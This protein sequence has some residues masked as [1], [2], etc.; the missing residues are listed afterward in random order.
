M[1]QY[2]SNFNSNFSPVEELLDPVHKLRVS[3]PQAL[4]DTDFEYGLQTTKW[5][6]LEL[7][8]NVPA[9]YTAD[10]DSIL[11]GVTSVIATA[12]SNV[13]VVNTNAPH[14]LVQGTPID[15]RGLSYVAAEGQFLIQTVPTTTSFTY[16]ASYTVPISG[17]ISTPYTAVTPGQ[18]YAGSNIPYDTSV[19]LV[20]DGANPSN[21]TVNTVATHG[22]AVNTNFYAVNTIGVK[23]ITLTST[24]T[25]APDGRPYVDYT[26][27][28][29]DNFTID[30][31]MTETEQWQSGYFLK[32]KSSDVSTSASTITWP[33]HG[34][35]TNDTVVYV[36]P[37]GDTAIGG[38]SRFQVYYVINAGTNTIQLSTSVNGGPITFTSAGTSNYG[39]H[40][41][42]MCY[43]IM[44]MYK[45]NYTYQTFIY[46]TA[47]Y[48]GNGYS[49][50]DLQNGVFTSNG[51][52]GGSGYYGK[53]A[54]AKYSMMFSPT[55]SYV[56]PNMAGP[57]YSTQYSSG[58][59]MPETNTYPS[60]YNFIE[61]GL[62]YRYSYAIGNQGN[63]QF[64]N[65]PVIY[66]NYVAYNQDY[67]GYYSVYFGNGN[68][69]MMFL[70]DDP[71]A[72]TFYYPNHNLQSG[73]SVTLTVSSGST[74][75]LFPVVNYDWFSTYAYPNAFITSGSSSVVNAVSANRFQLQIAGDASNF[76]APSG[77]SFSSGQSF[78]LSQAAGTYAIVGTQP[79]ALANTFYVANHG[80][81]GGEKV[82]LT[83]SGGGSALP[84]VVSGTPV[85]NTNLTTGNIG[86]AFG[87][88]NNAL[89]TQ[90]TAAGSKVQN[91]ILNGTNSQFYQNSGVSSGSSPVNQAGYYAYSY[92]GANSGYPASGSNNYTFSLSPTDLMAGTSTANEG[93]TVAGTPW[94]QNSSVPHYSS[95]YAGPSSFSPYAN[96]QLSP[97]IYYLNYGSVTAG[98]YQNVNITGDWYYAWNYNIVSAT[99][100]SAG[101][102]AFQTW[103]WKD[104]WN[105][106]HQ[107]WNNYAYV[108]GGY[109][110]PNL[111]N[112]KNVY[113]Q[114][115]TSFMLPANSTFGL[116]DLQ[117]IVAGVMSSFATNFAYPT[118][119]T[120]NP[121]YITLVNSNRFALSNQVFPY[122]L[123][124]AGSPNI[125]FKQSGVSGLLDGTYPVSAVPNSKSFVLSLPY[126]APADYVY[127][128]AT[129][130]ASNLIK[131][132]AGHFFTNGTKVT[133]NNGG[134]TTI[135][136]LTNNATYYV[137]V[138]DDYYIGFATSYANTG[139]KTL[140][141]ISAGTGANH[142]VQ[143]S[144]IN[145]TSKAVGTVST[146]AAS[147][148]ITGTNA[149]LFTRYFKV[150]DNVILKDASTT[151]GTLYTFQIA[152]I[153]NDQTMT[154]VGSV[155]FTQ[156][157]VSYFYSTKLYVRPDGYAIHRPYD[158]GIELAAGTA[159]SSSIARQT[160]KYFRYQPGKGIQSSAGI[161]FNPAVNFNSLVL[162]SSG[163]TTAVGTASG[164]ATVTLSSANTN[165]YVGQLVTGT[166]VPTG[167]YVQSITD[168]THVVLTKSVTISS[169]T[170]TFSGYIATGTTRYPHRLTAGNT[171]LVSNSSDAAY[172][173]TQTAA[174]I[175]D[176]YTFTMPLASNPSTTIPGGLIQW[177]PQGYSG[178]YTRVGMF[179]Y[180]NGFFF[181]F[182][183]S[184]LW[185]VRRS[186][187]QQLS[188]SAT[189]VFGSNTITGVG[190]NFTGQLSSGDKIVVRGGTYRV[191]EVTSNTS[192]AI[193][194]QYKGVS[195]TNVIISKTIDTRVPQ[196]QWSL[197]KCDGTGFTG[198]NLNINKIQM[199]YLDYSWYGAGK[200]R[201]GFKD[202]AGHIKYVHEFIH[203]NLQDI[204]YMRSGNL[205]ARYEIEN[206][207]NPTYV[208]KLY[209]WGT[210]VIMDGNFDPDKAYLITASSNNLTFTNGQAN[211]ATTTAGSYVTQNYNSS[212]RTY[213]WYNVLTFSS[214]DAGKFATGTPLY[215]A[216]GQLNGSQTV[217][218][219]QYSGGS[220]LVYIFLQSGYYYPYNY[221]TIS[222][223]IS[224]TA[225]TATTGSS[226]PLGTALI[227]LISLRLAPS[228][229]SNLI[230]NLG[231]REIIN[232][233]QLHLNEAEITTTHDS[234]IYMILNG[235]LSN[236]NF[237][238]AGKP[239]LSQYVPHQGGDTISGGLSLY[240]FRASGGSVDQG[241]GRRLSNTN[242]FPLSGITDMGNSILG[243]N[244]TFPNGPDVLTIAA[245]VID[246][247]GIGSSQPYL[248]TGRMSWSESQA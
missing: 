61:N 191:V 6:T 63:Y 83:P 169:I 234:T 89:N 138:Q 39:R 243:G 116:S 136:G 228:V 86:S 44:Y 45:P 73:T 151:P 104:S 175:V 153:T 144:V 160:R 47:A 200:I 3:T 71:E 52:N 159:P 35:H 65:S 92:D 59:V 33:N 96:V 240:S 88:F 51:V 94:I 188:G 248:I 20:S 80:Y 101:F 202:Q 186:S 60:Q 181:E 187:T 162:T 34:L 212:T 152:S 225:G 195:A 42:H 154:I 11:S 14:G 123:S 170:L 147:S 139:T 132:P 157:S 81:T 24:T 145:G 49:G 36:P 54:N 237:Q 43:E 245:K 201:F 182:D 167:T 230:G 149:T 72:D 40:K 233:M 192:I 53:A 221:A 68:L 118:L 235:G 128:D 106:F 215:S 216:D 227:P 190:T 247:T 158:G 57:I 137:Y 99:S 218:Y 140:V 107:T 226:I 10:A 197:D 1:S 120:V 18:F 93:F 156:T 113:I 174:V 209:H 198:Y 178:A 146:T 100:G 135:T 98:Y 177:N 58:M 189:V 25:T 223:G 219:T 102:V 115:T 185:C 238:N 41:L 105:G 173:G 111:Y 199:V 124:S 48:N 214:S 82:Y 193:Q 117:T 69:F 26:Q 236:F 91:T 231:A 165:I 205:P 108:G 148:L 229:D 67:Y 126:Q 109:G 131:V 143:Y 122:V 172:N 112:N 164:S 2:L 211:T 22:F 183:G 75:K 127:A 56:N 207:P 180:Q 21:I 31:T 50:W 133:Y 213:D 141:T 70:N 179:D 15:V 155:P 130:V 206:G 62:R 119:T 7:S 134:N 241:T 163:T 79:N 210:S 217:A 242:A 9:F 77:Y 150:G 142:Q 66:G 246:T 208:P 95:L 5:E 232:R 32:F 27:T 12:N 224:I 29:A 17:D 87:V 4:I 204:A 23:Q 76:T 244:Y 161:N 74:A 103:I 28:L 46:T 184:V 38:L 129:T 37:S 194:P 13:F 171:I 196:S 16:K 78:R 114:T 125:I 64:Q 222:N 239:S 168:S 8:N 110:Y 176:N 19:G 30:S 203:N 97:S 90:L 85:P 84:S 121:A 166:N 55:N 220:I